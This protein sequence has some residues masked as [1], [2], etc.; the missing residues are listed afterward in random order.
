MNNKFPV[1]KQVTNKDLSLEVKK[2]G[3]KQE[4]IWWW[5]YYYKEKN[6]LMIKEKIVGKYELFREGEK[7][8]KDFVAPTI[9]EW[10]RALSNDEIIK[11]IEET[12]GLRKG[13][14]KCL[15]YVIMDLLK[16]PNS[17]A[18]IWLHSREAGRI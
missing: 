17:M 14:D 9:S 8:I 12:G 5:G 7:R 18:E 2:A 1:E 4:G 11:Y 3:Y 6:G 13:Q 16:N 15:A 10:G